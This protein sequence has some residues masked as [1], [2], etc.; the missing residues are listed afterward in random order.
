MPA[1]REPGVY[2]GLPSADYHADP[3]LGSS[4]VKRLLQ[5]PAVYWWHS[6][7]NPDRPSSPDTVAMLKGRALHKLV[8]E[9]EEAL[10]K[11]F[12]EEPSPAGYPGCLATLDDLKAKCRELGEPVSGTKAELAKRIKAK[13]SNIIVFDE[14]LATF[15]AMAE[16]DGLEILKPDVM[17]EVRQAAASIT[18]NPHLARAFQGGIPEVSVFWVDEHGIPCKARLDWL[19]PRTIV[20]LKKCA[21]V[22]ERP[23]D[24]AVMLAIAEY[25]CDISAR[26]YLDG[27]RYLY[28]FAREGRVFGDCPLKPGWHQRI[29]PPGE[30]R[31]T[32]VFHQTEG[33]PVT[34][35]LELLPGSLALNRA[36]RE[37]VQAKE[38]YLTC[39]AKFS[40][41]QW[42]SDAPIAALDD[43]NL[44]SW[45]R[46]D[47]EEYA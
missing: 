33:A 44:P 39:L 19:K 17:R 23:F 47:V 42:I 34:K 14:V 27:Y 46:E 24:V 11:A 22:R 25:R 21:N 8:L 15:R 6:H 3:S 12:A 4:D 38:R 45:L 2:F 9:G 29:M 10:G 40:T 35:G 28:E 5:A 31:W 16:R 43:R 26:H 32:W 37:I 36:A 30:M 41:H 1:V 13:D 18:L 20:D 7:M